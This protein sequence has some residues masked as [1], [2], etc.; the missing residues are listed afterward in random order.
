[1]TRK[2]YNNHTIIL[3]GSIEITKWVSAKFNRTSTY[4]TRPE[5]WPK[6]L[7]SVKKQWY[8]NPIRVPR[9]TLVVFYLWFERVFIFRTCFGLRH[10]RERKPRE[11][12]RAPS[13]KTVAVYGGHAKRGFSRDA[14]RG[15]TG[16]TRSRNANNCARTNTFAVYTCEIRLSRGASKQQDSIF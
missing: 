4:Y 14:W 15:L 13:T 12:R 5:N 6:Y 10:S 7:R 1:M 9:N 8:E 3:Y 11:F 16:L 2:I